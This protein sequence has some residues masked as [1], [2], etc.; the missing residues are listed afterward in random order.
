MTEQHW[1]CLSEIVIVRHPVSMCV[2]VNHRVTLSVRVE[3]AAILQYQWFTNDNDVIN[4][5]GDIKA[6]FQDSLLRFLKCLI[7]DTCVVLLMS[8]DNSLVSFICCKVAG[9][10]EADLS[11]TATR[12]QMYVCRVN[13]MSRKYVFS[14]W[15]KV[16][17]LEMDKTGML[18]YF[19][20]FDESDIIIFKECVLCFCQSSGVASPSVLFFIIR[21]ASRLAG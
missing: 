14:D 10:T 13:D 19:S 11:I 9:G 1:F 4:D 16:K 12:T 15:V 2:P 18:C 8:T 7:T 3:S 20:L 5:V 6:F 17:V 21:F